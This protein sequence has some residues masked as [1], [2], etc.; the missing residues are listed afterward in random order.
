V[1][2]GDLSRKGEREIS[3]LGAI[4]NGGSGAEPAHRLR[5]TTLA[6]EWEK[7][8]ADGQRDAARFDR[9]EDVILAANKEFYGIKNKQLSFFTKYLNFKTDCIQPI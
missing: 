6:G 9:P 8:F 3:L 5:I 2:K 4:H 1:S 7:G